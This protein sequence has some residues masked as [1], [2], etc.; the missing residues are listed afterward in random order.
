MEGLVSE[1]YKPEE[2][3]CKVEVFRWLRLTW[4]KRERC[5]HFKD[6]EMDCG[7]LKKLL[8]EGGIPR[9]LKTRGRGFVLRSPDLHILSFILGI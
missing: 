3:E 2:L 6:Q 8:D 5:G 9:I 1:L 7:A 4:S